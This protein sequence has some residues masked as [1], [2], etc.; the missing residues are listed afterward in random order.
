MMRI[1]LKFL[2]V[3]SLFAMISLSCKEDDVTFPTSVQ[4]SYSL[5]G[6][7]AAFAALANSTTTYLWDFGDG[8]TSAERNPVHVYEDGGYYTVIIKVDG[9]TGTDADTAQLAVAITPYVLLTGGPTAANGKTWKLTG[10][11]QDK[12]AL[13][14]ASFTSVQATPAGTFGQIGFPEVYEDQYTFKFDGGYVHTVNSTGGAFAGYVNQLL[15][16][17]GANLKKTNGYTAQFD[18]CTANYTPQA[19]ATF[20]YTENKNFLIYPGVN[21]ISF[22]GTEFIGF[23]DHQREVIVQD[24]TDK[25]M[26]LAIFIAADPGTFP[27]AGYAL[28]ATFTAQ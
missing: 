16:D 19:G 8:T 9:S 24:I 28:I 7:Q 18:L 6:K 26:R 20:T 13:A 11:T 2:Y 15:T 1:R 12:F 3:F 17:G 23:W 14:N 25:S 4:L 10:S 27:T 5:E 22:S 21:T